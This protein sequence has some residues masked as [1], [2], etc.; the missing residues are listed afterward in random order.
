MSQ[1]FQGVTSGSLPPSV[2]TSFVTD[3]GTVVPSANIVNVNGGPGI[4]VI[5]NPN[6]SNN[7]VIN[8]TTILQA[9]TD[10]VGPTT[11][12]VLPTDYYISVNATG[13]A[14]TIKLP[15]APT[16]NQRFVVK[17]RLGV[18]ATNTITVQS[19]SG[20]VTIDQGANVTFIDN[21]ES[22]EVVFHGSNYEVF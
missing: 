9:Y 6:G 18:A 19:F 5:A 8:S 3:S 11:Y 13:G 22:L 1:F 17:D 10:V 15:D 16:T 4:Q 20:I 21:F 7:M 14:V 12:T 2:P